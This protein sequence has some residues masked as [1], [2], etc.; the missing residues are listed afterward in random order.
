[1]QTIDSTP[2]L[3]VALPYVSD[4]GPSSFALHVQLNKPGVVHYA[5]YY[6]TYYAKLEDQRG[7]LQLQPTALNV[8]TAPNTQAPTLLPGSGPAGAST[9]DQQSRVSGSPDPYLFAVRTVDLTPP[10]FTGDTPRTAN[11]DYTSTDLVVQMNK[12]GSV[13]YVVLG[14]GAPDPSVGEV[15]AGSGASGASVIAAGRIDVAS[16][17]TD[18]RATVMGLTVNTAYD[19]Y[20][21]GQDNN[22]TPNVMANWTMITVRT[23][24]NVPPKFSVVAVT[25][26]RKGFADL[27]VALDESAE[28]R[29]VL[30]A[31]GTPAP[32]MAQ[33]F[34]GSIDN[35]PAPL[36]SGT[37][38]APRAG[39]NR[40]ATL[41]HIQDL[42]L[43]TVWLA[44]QDTNARPNRQTAVTQYDFATP[45][46]TP[47]IV[48]ATIVPLSM[49]KGDRFM[50]QLSLSKPGQVY[51]VVVPRS[52]A[53]N[54]QLSA[55]TIFNSDPATLFPGIIAANGTL[56][57]LAAFT[58]IAQ[59]VTGVPS[60]TD[61][62][63]FLAAQDTVA[64][65]NFAE[66]PPILP[67]MT[68][69]V[70]P[71]RWEGGAP[72]AKDLQETAFNLVMQIDE[73]GMIFYAVMLE[74]SGK[75]TLANVLKGMVPRALMQGSVQVSQRTLYD[76]Y[77][78]ARDNSDPMN[79]QPAPQYRLLDTS[80]VGAFTC[81]PK[82]FTAHL[83]P[84]IQ[85]AGS[86]PGLPMGPYYSDGNGSFF[87]DFTAFN[88]RAPGSAI[89]AQAFAGG[90]PITAAAST[91][92]A[93]TLSPPAQIEATVRTV[94]LWNEDFDAA[95][96][97]FDE[98]RILSVMFLSINC[99]GRAPGPA[100]TAAAQGPNVPLVD[101]LFQVRDNVAADQAHAGFVWAGQ[102]PQLGSTVRLVMTSD[103]SL[104]SNI[105]T[106]FQALVHD[107]RGGAQWS[108]QIYV[109]SSTTVGL[110][111]YADQSELFNLAPLTGQSVTAT[112]SGIQVQSWFR[113]P[114]DGS[115]VAALPGFSCLDPSA[116]LD[117]L[118]VKAA[119]AGCLVTVSA[120]GTSS[121]TGL[122]I[123]VTS[124]SVST[125][126]TIQVWLPINIRVYVDDPML[127]R[128]IPPNQVSQLPGTCATPTYQRTSI[129]AFADL[130]H[131][132]PTAVIPNLEL[133]DIVTFTSPMNGTA[134][135]IT[136]SSVQGLKAQAGVSIGV[137]RFGSLGASA[138]L[139]VVDDYV[140]M[141][142][143]LSQENTPAT[144]RAYASFSDGATF[145]ITDQAGSGLAITS[146][147]TA[148]LALVPAQQPPQ[149]TVT[150][151]F[152]SPPVCGN[153]LLASY[154]VCSLPVSGG[155][156]PVLVDLPIPTSV[157]AFAALPNGITRA[158][159]PAAQAPIAVPVTA[160]LSVNVAFNDG[161]IRDYSRDPRAV[162]SVSAGASLCSVSRPTAASPGLVKVN[163]ASKATAFGPCAITVTF[164][165]FNDS[166]ITAVSP[167]TVVILDKVVLRT[168]HY[169]VATLPANLG[170]VATRYTT[171][172][173]IG[174]IP[175]DWQQA[176][177]WLIANITNGSNYDVTA[178]AATKL[179]ASDATT[180][181]LIRNVGAAQ[182]G[183]INR[184]RPIKAGSIVLNGSFVTAAATP[185]TLTLGGAST[186]ASVQ[187]VALSAGWC[188]SGS[189]NPQCAITFADVAGSNST[190]EAKV[191][192]NDGYAYTRILGAA[193][194]ALDIISVPGLLAFT[195]SQPT[196]IQAQ[197][198]GDVQLLQNSDAVVSLTAKTQPMCAAGAALTSAVQAWA[199]LMPEELDLDLGEPYGL[200]LQQQPEGAVPAYLQPGSTF[201]MDMRINSNSSQ[202]NAFQI[203][204]QYDST[205]L[206]VASEAS[207]AMGADWPAQPSAFVCN[208]KG[209]PGTVLFNSVDQTNN[210]QKQSANLTVA[211]ITF[212]AQA[213]GEG[214]ITATILGVA[215]ASGAQVQNAPTVAGTTLFRIGNP[216]AGRRLRSL[217][218][219]F[220]DP[221]AADAAIQL[222]PASPESQ[223]ALLEGR[224][225]GRSLLQTCTEAADDAVYGDVNFDCKFTLVQDVTL[226]DSLIGA[227]N[228]AAPDFPTN[229][230]TLLSQKSPNNVN[231]AA[232]AHQRQQLDPS[233]RYFASLPRSDPNYLPRPDGS[234]VP[235][236]VGLTA[237]AL[238]NRPGS[239]EDKFLL[240]LIS[241]DLQYFLTGV[242]VTL[243]TISAPQLNVTVG[244]QDSKSQL[245]SSGVGVLVQVEL[246][247]SAA[248]NFTNPA[249]AQA[250]TRTAQGT[251]LAS[252]DFTAPGQFSISASPPA[253]PSNMCG[254]SIA[255]PL[256][257]A[258]VVLSLDASNTPQNQS[259][260]PYYGSAQKA[261][262]SPAAP[263]A[264][265]YKDRFTP[266]ANFNI[267]NVWAPAYV[268]GYPT[269]INISAMS[270][271]LVANL[272]TP[273][274]IHYVVLPAA[275]IGALPGIPTTTAATGQAVITM[276]VNVTGLDPATNYTVFLAAQDSNGNVAPTA[277][278]LN[279][280]I[281]RDSIPPT[282]TSIALLNP[283]IDQNAGTFQLDLEASLT[284]P[285]QVFYAIYRD[286]SCVSGDPAI[287]D[288]LAGLALPPAVCSCNTTGECSVVT[289]GSFLVDGGLSSNQTLAGQLSP[290]P[291]EALRDTPVDQLK[292]FTT[293]LA[294]ATDNYK[295]YLVARDNITT[296]N[297]L[298]DACTV[299]PR[300]IL[301][302]SGCVTTVF[303]DCNQARVTPDIP[304]LQGGSYLPWQN[305]G[306]GSYVASGAD[307]AFPARLGVSLASTN[308]PHFTLDP[309]FTPVP[310]A[311]EMKFQLDQPGLLIYTVFNI[312]VPNPNPDSGIAPPHIQ[313]ANGR[314]PV[315]GA[316]D[317]GD[318]NITA[319]SPYT[320]LPGQQYLLEF[321]VRDKH[322]QS[323]SV[324]VNELAY[325]GV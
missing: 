310:G 168:Q 86:S 4:I 21:V 289:S 162:Y 79:I 278:V 199:N 104:G 61:L 92:I 73:P 83:Q 136:G 218:R 134:I 112:I 174:C 275:Q 155:N 294:H 314:V 253:D 159:D 171:L 262:Y 251:Y 305:S 132:E 52:P 152:G 133:T 161:S 207:C 295:V 27:V 259:F 87:R 217:P 68:P 210:P 69:D 47:P 102:D 261:L 200:V 48:N 321:W 121:T 100:N 189:S 209:T 221:A 29:Y 53:V 319:C 125:A 274:D 63:V 160:A 141:A 55:R 157:S 323:E 193:R 182:A 32:S 163:A 237:G 276:S 130:S 176:T 96:P 122:P 108:A 58:T 35:S 1:M 325:T 119:A 151:F 208:A 65:P 149:A 117:T 267:T 139:D 272:Y 258:V 211:S 293:S 64:P 131:G 33:V 277:S 154:S 317:I 192:L 183:L 219:P 213:A 215:Q 318:I 255:G 95:T 205:L 25:N 3:F 113:D 238:D 249:A 291:F 67:V 166:T 301:P 41:D 248:L 236:L 14:K 324:A 16:V 150:A 34:N 82:T 80:V 195:S 300:T 288:E 201:R 110:H 8:T 187:S 270:F 129:H 303:N 127:N 156:G 17:L 242:N 78:V 10:S 7:N 228:P 202:L 194:D 19:V 181:K 123:L 91:P 84:S 197:A 54:M 188:T 263:G 266:Y 173:Q 250:D 153:V 316:D 158:S 224:Q 44:A 307:A 5:V 281:T 239:K 309:Q 138:S 313:I 203:R 49:A 126:V 212:T 304:N 99:G 77:I 252:A 232:T 184:L 231:G 260:W 94:N 178:A 271:V 196:V 142:K 285:A 45:D 6:Q 179:K 245:L 43:Y 292:C 308:L 107:A 105:A 40:T 302:A 320:M 42:S 72:L 120:A 116:S 103:S 20:L 59:V 140:C 191:V 254:A 76:V 284:E 38:Y 273:A 225:E 220:L 322:G 89:Q 243:P 106:Q 186:A 315:F 167:V 170:S 30:T 60:N 185:L 75:P 111:A 282:F 287:G 241:A 233:Y 297:G 31:Q 97:G 312:S 9:A 240:Q 230:Y 85:L 26:M 190:L 2:P 71:P 256:S 128:F 56:Q 223:V 169:D 235:D 114:T 90:V 28:V 198:F 62:L 269:A 118:T 306:N 206:S 145:D 137:K 12:L 175:A 247:T 81:A 39:T 257:I 164:P 296:Y 279:G 264:A 283:I 204:V 74:T 147:N 37:F 143:D 214:T 172:K 226:L 229:Y 268:P 115:N 280:I 13:Y 11:V 88:S 57:V 36:D 227:W 216:P 146:N 148:A 222:D 286:Y 298:A 124:G 18:A 135:A 70:T 180:A 109:A 98:G 299:R 66:P 177:V 93:T 311:I 144:V 50:L 22:P 234:A 15:Q 24:D 101:L 244:L 51:Y 46:L 165:S 246:L 23:S 265:T 290:L